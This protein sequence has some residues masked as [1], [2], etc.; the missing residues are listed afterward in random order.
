MGY[1]E[2]FSAFIAMGGH[3]PYVWSSYGVTL[4]VL[5]WL[6]VRPLGRKRQLLN[7]LRR[8]QRRQASVNRA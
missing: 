1:F 7:Q 2:D 6:L 4:V 5:A 3:G 8:Q